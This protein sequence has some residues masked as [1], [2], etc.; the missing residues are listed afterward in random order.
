VKNGSE[1]PGDLKK[2]QQRIGSPHLRQRLWL[3]SEHVYK[4]FGKGRTFVHFENF[5]WLHRV[6]SGVIKLSGFYAKGS[7]NSRKFEVATNRVGLV[8]LPPPFSGF[9]ILHLTDLH[10][11]LDPSLTTYLRSTL[12]N[13]DHHLCVITG[14]FRSATFGDYRRCLWEA[15]K[16]V[17]VL[18]NPVYGILGNHDFIEMVTPLEEMGIQ[19]LLNEA[20]KIEL[21]DEAIWLAGVDDPHFYQTDNLQEASDPIST[22]SVAILLSHSPEIY[23]QAAASGFDL[24]LCGH[25]H[26]GQICLPGGIPVLTN[27]NCPREY[28]A[29]QWRYRGLSGYTSRGVGCSGVPVRFNCLPEIVV[30]ELELAD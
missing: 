16:V 10:L 22:D 11:D 27:G 2:L 19:L 7:A 12:Q 18:P 14:D 6:I 9:R 28:V 17:E 26:G 1:Q 3:Q 21:Q 8:G 24:M 5:D 4:K 23:R 20:V 25:T 15:A 30:H 13:I 29:G